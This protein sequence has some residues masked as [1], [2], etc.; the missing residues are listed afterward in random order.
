[1][2]QKIII[3][4]PFYNCEN[5]IEKCINSVASQNYENYEHILIDDCSTDNSFEIAERCIKPYSNFKLIKNEIN[6]G[7]VFNQINTLRTQNISSDSIIMFL[8]GD[9][10]LVN[11]PNIFNF[12]N[13]LYDE[14]VEFTYGSCW[15]LVDN[16]PLI[17]QEYPPE[18][19]KE[20]SYRKYKFN[21][22]IPY[23]HLRT[24]RKYLIDSIPDENFK[25]ENLNWYR[26]GGDN[27]TFYNILEEADSNKIKA[28][29]DIIYV[30]NDKNPLNDYKINSIEQTNNATYIL[31]NI[32]KK[33]NILIAIPTAKYIE[34]DTFKSIYDLIIPEGCK[35][36]YQHFYR[37]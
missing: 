22:N 8:D 33:K 25:D 19:K 27:S 28:I 15:S 32:M 16:I 5:Y 23:T 21:W 13:N 6:K 14:S 20:K 29:S 18:V 11:D 10:W 36:T 34:S 4:S 26:A 1:M 37:V 31:N 9:D 30:Y 3:I 12:Y 35:V 17:A 7:A 24:F 2:E